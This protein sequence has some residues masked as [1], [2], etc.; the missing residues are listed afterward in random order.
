MLSKDWYID[1]VNDFVDNG[2]E[3]TVTGGNLKASNKV[4]FDI[5]E[6]N[7]L[8]REMIG[9]IGDEYKILNLKT[10]FNVATG[11]SNFELDVCEYL[12]DYFYVNKGKEKVK[13]LFNSSELRYDN[14]RIA[15]VFNGFTENGKKV[16]FGLFRDFKR[17]DNER[18]LSDLDFF[19]N[20]RGSG[21]SIDHDQLEKAI[22]LINKKNCK[23][24]FDLYEFDILDLVKTKLLEN[25]Q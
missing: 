23:T 17:V 25:N 24:D 11:N 22:G 6:V 2:Y 3:I 18:I 20:N 1:F 13:I 21:I 12:N 7:L 10:Y 15:M 14:Y 16:I 19:L 8:L 9:K 5:V 4:D